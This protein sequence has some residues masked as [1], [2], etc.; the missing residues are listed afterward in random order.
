MYV[1]LEDEKSRGSIFS[2]W[3]LNIVSVMGSNRWNDSGVPRFERFSCAEMSFINHASVFE[4]DVVV[5]FPCWRAQILVWRAQILVW[6]AQILIWRAQFWFEGHIFWF[7]G[8]RFWFE[9]DRFWFEGHRYWFEGHRFW[10]ERHR[11]WFEGHRFWFWRPQIVIWRHTDFDLKATDF[12][13][14][15]TDFDLKATDWWSKAR[16]NKLSCQRTRAFLYFILP[17]ADLF[18]LYSSKWFVTYIWL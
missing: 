13:L 11:F 5:V 3:A 14:K 16:S 6:R 4:V 1:I 17:L 10:F 2:L 18:C 7:E 8:H 15:A 9:S 12:D